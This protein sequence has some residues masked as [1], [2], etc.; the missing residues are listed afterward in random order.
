[1]TVGTFQ[2]MGEDSSLIPS[3]SFAEGGQLIQRCE[4]DAERNACLAIGKYLG[5][6]H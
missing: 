1:M 2:R 5:L 4:A 3:Q 6:S